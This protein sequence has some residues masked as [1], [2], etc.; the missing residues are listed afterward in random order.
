MKPFLVAVLLLF[1]AHSFAQLSS[2]KPLVGYDEAHIKQ[3]VTGYDSFKEAY[4]ASG[5]TLYYTFTDFAVMYG[6]KGN[7]KCAKAWIM[8]NSS[9]QTS[10]MNQWYYD[11]GYNSKMNTTTGDYEWTKNISIRSNNQGVSDNEF[12]LTSI[13][14]D[15]TSFFFANKVATLLGY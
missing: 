12:I 9:S 15:E 4:S 2:F 10:S 5:K 8:F 13:K 11:N 6:L 14:L 3:T 7:G 1:A